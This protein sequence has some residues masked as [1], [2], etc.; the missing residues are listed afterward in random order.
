MDNDIQ[1]VIADD[2]LFFA[3]ALEESLNLKNGFEVKTIISNLIDLEEYCNT[4]TFD[5]L[6]LDINFKGKNSLD[7][8]TRIR[9][10]KEDFKI[11]VLT[12]LNDTFNRTIAEKHHVELFLSKEASF[13]DFSTTLLQCYENSNLEGASVS[14][15]KGVEISGVNF[16]ETKIRV[17]RSLYKYSGRTE[18][19]IAKELHISESS[20]KTHKRQLYEMT[21]TNRIAD[22]LKFGFENGILLQ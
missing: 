19:E 18:K 15:K 8:L 2:N 16:T 4:N 1:L 11:I 10:Q 20:L 21:D 17:L 22:L 5:I 12:S 14:H 7:Y 3:E 13:K 6:I 9:K